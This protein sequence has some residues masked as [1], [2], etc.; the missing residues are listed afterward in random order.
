MTI[1]ILIIHVLV[2]GIHEEDFL[3]CLWWTKNQKKGDHVKS[4]QT[5]QDLNY[6]LQIV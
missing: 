6:A 5:T 4:Q 2:P 3:A 1:Y